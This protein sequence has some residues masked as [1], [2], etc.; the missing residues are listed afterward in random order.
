MYSYRFLIAIL[1]ACGFSFVSTSDWG[2]KAASQISLKMNFWARESLNLTPRIDERIKI[3]AVDDETISFL[4]DHDLSFSMWQ[5]LLTGIGARKP[6]AIYIDKVFGLIP[7]DRESLSQHAQLI[8]NNA[9]VYSGSFT[10]PARIPKRPLYQYDILNEYQLSAFIDGD[11]SDL[12]KIKWLKKD[13]FFT[14][15]A[16]PSVLS[17]FA[18]IGHLNYLGNGYITPIKMGSNKALLPHLAFS[19]AKIK[20]RPDYISVNDQKVFLDANGRLLANLLPAADFYKRAYK[21][22]SPIKQMQLGQPITGI[23]PNDYV[24]IL[25]LMYTGNADIYDSPAGPIPGGFILSA[26]INS[27]LTGEWLKPVGNEVVFI[28]LAITFAYVF[29]FSSNWF[30]GIMFPIFIIPVLIVFSGILSFSYLGYVCPWLYPSA[31]ASFLGIAIFYDKFRK[32]E[33][34]SRQLKHALGLIVPRA[35]LKSLIKNPSLLHR[36]PAS[37]KA[38]IMFIDMVGFSLS[39]EKQ[40]PKQVFDDLKEFNVMCRRLI[41]QHSGIVDK[42]LGD[43]ILCYF[44]HDLFGSESEAEGGN[45]TNH[46]LKA[47]E[48]AIEIQ[49]S[50]VKRCI[51][52]AKLNRNVYPLRIGINT[53]TVYIGNLGDKEQVEFTIVG[54][55][56]NYAKRLEEGCESFKILVGKETKNLLS[57]QVDIVGQLQP[58]LLTIKH[59]GEI[60]ESY[61]F[62]PF[63]KDS[64]EL[65][66]ALRGYQESSGYSRKRDRW[67]LSPEK[68]LHVFFN[69]G[70]GHIT[71]FSLDG[72]ALR[73]NLFFA[74][75]VELSLTLAADNHKAIY[76]RVSKEGY[77]PIVVEVRW[78]R[79]LKPG[80]FVH[81]LEIKGLN[82][83]QRQELF[84]IFTDYC[85]ADLEQALGFV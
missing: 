64:K 75:G 47:L 81:G 31:S 82:R 44:G 33:V 11:E 2:E 27:T 5:Q 30:F 36:K 41:H 51:K 35:T 57:D 25:P 72:M 60:R 13:N 83:V 15:A 80:L 74:R 18:G 46:A 38:T 59:H 53:A 67:D 68:Y 8:R 23:N 7:G 12:D 26:I 52:H 76:S 45:N 4:S 70:S 37:H 28:L 73:S 71:S 55:G 43:G 54:D 49:F 48:C 6:K 32:V 42:T 29:T 84:K 22:L 63:T 40:T 34:R 61:E 24:V 50:S 78:G 19:A 1:I 69:H 3:Y 17:A 14:Y 85:S 77:L 21:L 56:V 79:Q 9:S 16:D 62:D 58:K 39:S 66:I 20:L 65:G 10:S